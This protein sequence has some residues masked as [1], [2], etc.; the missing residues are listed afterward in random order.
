MTDVDD[1]DDEQDEHAAHRGRA[2]LDEMALR[3][4]G[5]HLLPD[6]AEPHEPDPQREQHSRG[7]QRQHDHQEDLVG[8]V[9]RLC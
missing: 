7:D 4:V 5:A 1:R 9:P 3:A 8:R 2:L 6:V